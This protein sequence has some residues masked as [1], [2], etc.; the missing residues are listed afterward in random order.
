VD[1]IGR[2]F[3]FSGHERTIVGVVGDIRVRGLERSS[4]PQ[5]YLPSQQIR[6]GWML[7]HSPKEL[8]IR[9][10]GPP[11]ALVAPLRRIIHAADPEQPVSNVRTLGDIV[12]ADTAPRA[13]QVRVLGAFAALAI[14]LAGIG[15]HGLLSY[16]V[17]Q[18]SQEIGVR[19]ALGAQRSDILGL[20][21]R[22]G[23][24]LAGTGLLLGVGLAYAAGRSMQT[25]LAQV[26]PADPAA[27]LT[28]VGVC[29]AMTLAG[30]LLPA[31]RAIRVDPNRA[32]RI[33]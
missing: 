33:E 23:L 17:S 12:A 24:L 6:D 20:V 25:L 18:R 29:L 32:I 8:V 13:V 15:I 11:G 4:E 22:D 30:C 2:R 5:V 7:G 14:L 10:S 27:F 3:H 28:A 19:I 21:L 31:L 9:T 16:T 1:P 26:A